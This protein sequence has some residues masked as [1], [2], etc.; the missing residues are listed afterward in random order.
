[1]I[2]LIFHC[3]FKNWIL[4]NH[5]NYI[6]NYY[7]FSCSLFVHFCLTYNNFFNKNE[8]S[9]FQYFILLYSFLPYIS[10]PKYSTVNFDVIDAVNA[11]LAAAASTSATADIFTKLRIETSLENAEKKIG[12]VEVGLLYYLNHLFP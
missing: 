10:R 7:I 12:D 3:F 11:R 9:V 1:M 6:I 8:L 2:H 5:L 4:P